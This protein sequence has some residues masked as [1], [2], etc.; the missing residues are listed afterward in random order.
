MTLTAQTPSTQYLAELRSLLDQ[1][2]DNFLLTLPEIE[3]LNAALKYVLRGGGKRTRPTLLLSL[4]K[5]LQREIFPY[6][7][8]SLA[9]ELMHV[10]SLV[11]DDLPALDND[12]KRRDKNTCHIEFNEA[13]AILTGDA[14]I[15]SAFNC[16]IRAPLESGVKLKSIEILSS[17]FNS[18]CFGQQLDLVPAAAARDPFKT[19]A[20]K[21]GALFS[22][23]TSLPFVIADFSDE[24]IQ[25]AG[26]CGLHVGICFQICDDIVDLDGRWEE[27]GIPAALS[28]SRQ[29][30]V[31]AL[32]LLGDKTAIDF[33]FTRAAL[34][35]LFAAY[36]GLDLFF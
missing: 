35:S 33:V 32:S 31:S 25:I 9:L 6:L 19:A 10:A 16:I 7:P 17:A 24:L 21:T 2:I 34:N 27:E 23:S 20:L 22:A 14:L 15:S 28:E 3:P 5:D 30:V 8:L 29:K 36:E 26:Q 1:E 13:T 18:L 4:V 11:H 12:D